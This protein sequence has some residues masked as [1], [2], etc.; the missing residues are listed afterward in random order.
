[1]SVTKLNTGKVVL[2]NADY[3]YITP[4]TD[5]DTIGTT[6]YDVTEIV[7]DSLSFTPDDNTI[8]SKDSEFADVPLFENVLLGKVQFATNCTD[9]QNTIMKELMGWSEEAVGATDLKGVFAPTSY[10]DLWIKIE[11]GFN[12]SNK[13]VVAPKVKLNSKAVISTLK[14]G[15]AE[16][17]LAGTCYPELVKA[18]TMT[19]AKSTTLCILPL[20]VASSVKVASETS[21]V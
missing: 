2:S 12:N 8:N 10:K 7:A 4:Y 1:M 6:T 15:S 3:L 19:T 11:V 5:E 17:Q 20:S 16:G 14:T 21:G 18:G 9:L 13:I